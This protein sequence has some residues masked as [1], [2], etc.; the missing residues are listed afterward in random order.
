MAE[1]DKAA[2]LARAAAGEYDG[3]GGSSS[4]SDQTNTD[5]GT[6]SGNSTSQSAGDQGGGN[7]DRQRGTD[8]KFAGKA[9]TGA[10]PPKPG[11]KGQQA[12]VVQVKGQPP[13][14]QQGKPG[15]ADEGDIDPDN[16]DTWKPSHRI[17]YD[18]FTKVI[19]ERDGARQELDRLK[20]E[21]ENLRLQASLQH[22]A[23]SANAQDNDDQAV[24]DEMFGPDPRRQQQT[25]NA[26]E[27]WQK[28]LTPIQRE[29]QEIRTER[30][31]QQIQRTIDSV[32]QNYPDVEEDALWQAAALGHKDLEAVAEREQARIN[33]WMEQGL[34]KAQAQ[35]ASQQGA[36]PQNAPAGQSTA[37][38]Q[39]QAAPPRPP[40]AG[41]AA[42]AGKGSKDGVN[43]A[44]PEQRKAWIM[45]QAGNLK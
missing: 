12:P 36:A 41:S 26:P 25:G 45:R 21:N 5:A 4:D 19:G 30:V 2:I 17:G 10:P 23:P 43:F 37:A 31:T 34:T 44:D 40:V 32:R 39:R 28:A 27:P 33:K 35:R 42:P 20:R 8:G 13:Q 7:S 1:K 11:S 18:R 22:R 15:S 29:L 16:R 14:Q 24:L 6:D 9:D 3:A 38:P